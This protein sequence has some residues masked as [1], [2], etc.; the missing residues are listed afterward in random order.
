[1]SETW[2]IDLDGVIWR[3]NSLIAGSDEAVAALRTANKRV[4]FFTNNSFPLVSSLVDKLCSMNIPASREDI[5]TSAMAASRLLK[6]KSKVLCLGGPGIYEALVGDGHNPVFGHGIISDALGGTKYVLPFPCDEESLSVE[7]AFRESGRDNLLDLT[8]AGIE[9]F[10]AIDKAADVDSLDACVVGIDP[11]FNFAT[12]A[13]GF[14]AVSGGARLIATNDDGTYPMQNGLLP[15]G[16]ILYKA[17]Q[18]LTNTSGEV[19]GKPYDPAVELVKSTFGDVTYVVGDRS[20]TD[21]LLA[22]R[23][24]AR[25]ALVYS[26]VT[27]EQQKNCNAVPFMA[28][29]DLLKVVSRILA[30]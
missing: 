14:R 26:G 24:G 16:G 30:S 20:D 29:E 12:L 2:L 15:G 19:A 18:F 13:L 6:G 27:A 28:D 25:F 5:L 7:S 21:G 4:V 3:G 17:L 10:E 11:F 9:F 1:M 8:Q 22:N 23:L